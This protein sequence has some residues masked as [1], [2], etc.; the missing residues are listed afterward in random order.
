[1]YYYAHINSSDLVDAVYA[2]DTPVTE[3]G[4][5]EITEEQYNVPII[6]YRYYADTNY[7]E[8]WFWTGTTDDVCYPNTFTMVTTILDDYAN[9]ISNK[10]DAD[11]TH[12]EYASKVNVTVDTTQNMLVF[13][14]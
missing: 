2:F 8:E 11:H 1:M 14:T 13:S 3:D 12:P 9:E 5:V 4:Y 6:R 7:F 10:A